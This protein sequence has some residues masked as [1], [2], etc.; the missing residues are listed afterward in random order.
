[1]YIYYTYMNVC[2]YIFLTSSITSEHYFL[3]TAIFYSKST[4]ICTYIYTV[5][6][7]VGQVDVKM[8]EKNFKKA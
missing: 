4:Y 1:M 2:V 3:M 8:P 6:I 5:R 7:H